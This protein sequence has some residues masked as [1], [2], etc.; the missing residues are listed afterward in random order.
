MEIQVNNAFQ[1][2][3]AVI[4]A[5]VIGDF[6]IDDL[7]V[8]TLT[9]T[10]ITDGTATLTGGNFT[11]LVSTTST[12]FYDD[13]GA[14]I[15]GGNITVGGDFSA[16]IIETTGGA[17][18]TA[19]NISSTNFS[20]TTITTGAS[21]SFA[22]GPISIDNTEITGVT[23]ATN[24]TAITDGV[25]TL[26]GGN[27]DDLATVTA[28]TVKDGTMQFTGGDM[29]NAASITATTVYTPITDGIGTIS[30]T[31]CTGFNRLTSG[32]FNTS[33]E[34]SLSDEYATIEL[35]TVG[36]VLVIVSESR[37][38][39][40]AVVMTGMDTGSGNATAGN[41]LVAGSGTVVSDTLY[42]P[43]PPLS[44]MYVARVPGTTTLQ[45]GNGFGQPW[46][47]NFTFIYV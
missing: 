34:L 24:T 23:S 22:A 11:G 39:P 37:R 17:L 33:V 3:T 26:T 25:A 13:T 9:A 8:E 40:Q 12:S 1:A 38:T 27:F 21:G 41:Y 35:D 5:V 2:L 43:P 10:T 16:I 36:P 30:A 20:A 7:T 45:I 28:T 18:I 46:N 31:T 14:E 32:S 19:T 6:V 42:N 47:F 15:T 44:R 4:D 29:T